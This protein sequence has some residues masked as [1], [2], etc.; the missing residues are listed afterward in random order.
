MEGF[1]S[2]DAVLSISETDIIDICCQIEET[3]A[4]LYRH[5]ALVYAETPPAADLWE[6]TAKEEDNHAAQFHLAHRLLGVGLKSF[7][8]DI[9]TAASLLE[10][11]Q[12]V[13]ANVQKNPPR[14]REAL[15]F[16]I[17]LEKAMSAYHMHAIANFEDKSLEKLFIAMMKSDE[18]HIEMLVNAL[19][20]L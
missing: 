10:K 9:K 13:Y 14:L 8:T 6:K 19:E 12:T 3:C 17:S 2:R 15:H 18:Q 11:I 7:N 20:A 16:A 4:C 5:F 1:M